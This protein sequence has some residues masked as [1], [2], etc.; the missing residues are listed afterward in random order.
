VGSNYDPFAAPQHKEVLPS[1]PLQRNMQKLFIENRAAARHKPAFFLRNQAV[2][3]GFQ[4][5]GRR[6]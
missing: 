6:P 4:E 2:M 3:A 5:G 1:Y